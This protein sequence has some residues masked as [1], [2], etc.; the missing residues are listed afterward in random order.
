MANVNTLLA[1]QTA[2]MLEALGDVTAIT[3]TPAG[4]VAR[5]IKAIVLRETRTEEYVERL[6]NMYNTLEICISARNDTEGMLTPKELTRTQAPDVFVIDGYT[7]ILLRVLER[8][9]AGMHRLKL[10]DQGKGS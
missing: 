2:A 3:V 5:T 9:N 7:W 4:G 6:A 8:N 1:A 10:M